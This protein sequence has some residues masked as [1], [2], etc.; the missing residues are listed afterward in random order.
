[1]SVSA[2]RG[3]LLLGEKAVGFGVDRDVIR[4][5]QGEDWYRDR[6][7]RHAALHCR[8]Q[9]RAHDVDPPRLLQRL[10]RGLPRRSAD[11]AGR[12]SCRSICAAS[13]ATSGAS[14]WSTARVRTSAARPSSGCSA[15]RRASDRGRGPGPMP[16][17]GAGRDWVELGCQQVSL[18][19]KDRDSIRVGRREGRFKAIRL[20]ARGA[21][22]EM[23]NLGSSTPTASRTI[24]RPA[25][26]SAQGETHQP[27]DLRGWERAIDRVDMVYGRF[28]TS[29]AR[30]PCASKDC[31][32]SHRTTSARLAR[33][34]LRGGPRCVLAHGDVIDETA[35]HVPSGSVES[36]RRLDAGSRRSPKR[37]RRNQG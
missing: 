12:R 37:N 19:G 26:S 10:R 29:K 21:D 11:P 23:L 28:P 25:I 33:A 5:G 9:R 2:T 1:M 18:F 36:C 24:S 32:R 13:A 27:L 30:R 4:I 31:S 17:P 8:G 16:G 20:H 34:A 35:P 22:V 14:R 15:S 6:R 7:F 3:W